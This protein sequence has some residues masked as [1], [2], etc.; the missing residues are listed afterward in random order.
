MGKV[1][2]LMGGTYNP[3][4]VGH[5]AMA[6]YICEY[7]GV[8]ELWMMVTPC[9][10]FKVNDEL[11]DE[12]LRYMMVE[13]AVADYPKIK[14]CDFECMLERP[15]YTYKTL[16]AL[17]HAYPDD[18][19]VLVVGADNWVSFDKWRCPEEI[20]SHHDVLIYGRPGVNVLSS[21]LPSNVRM[22]DAPLL[23]VSSTFIRQSVAAG[24]DVRYFTHPMVWQIIVEQGLYHN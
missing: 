24:R 2:A 5:L 10:P 4:H 23:D 18:R 6:N 8:D 16:A 15:S 11:L 14:A 13:A 7:C 21:A 19:F 17:R 12:H 9:N 3:P 1:I 22:V 20:L